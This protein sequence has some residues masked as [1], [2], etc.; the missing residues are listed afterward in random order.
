MINQLFALAMLVLGAI[1]MVT[2]FQIDNALKGDKCDDTQLKNCNKGILVMGTVSVVASLS[3][4][5]CQSKCEQGQSVV[6]ETEMYAGF[7]LAL[8]IVIVVLASIIQSRTKA[9]QTCSDAKAHTNLITII[10]SIMIVVSTGYLGMYAYENMGGKDA[11]KRM[12]VGS[13]FKCSAM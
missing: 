9:V 12:R 5:I 11:Y 4:L 3:Y 2:N 10:G 1:L 13:G 6:F 7:C 8:G